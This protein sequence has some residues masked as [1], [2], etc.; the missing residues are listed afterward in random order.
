VTVGVGV[1]IGGTAV[2]ESAVDVEA[3]ARVSGSEAASPN[4]SKARAAVA[5]NG[6]VSNADVDDSASNVDVD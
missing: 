3:V 1:V 4:G 2:V 6:S 5:F